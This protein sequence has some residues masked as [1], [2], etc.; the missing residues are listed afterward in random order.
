[1]DIHKF[2]GVI[3]LIEPEDADEEERWAVNKHKTAAEELED[4]CEAIFPRVRELLSRAAE[5]HAITLEAEIADDVGRELTQALSQTQTRKERRH[6]K[7]DGEHGTV[8]PRTTGRKRRKA[9]HS[10][11]GEGSVSIDEPFSGKRF[12]IIMVEEEERFGWVEGNRK[13]NKVYLGRQHEYWIAHARDR[14]LVKMGAMALLTGHAITTEDSNQPIMSAVIH[15][16]SADQKF[17]LTL[18]NMA[19]QVAATEEASV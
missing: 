3:T 19:R 15:C 13:S 14:H 6:R 1:M 10:D 8:L 9:R 12:S 11:A 16:D 18:G 17:Q 4:L 7:E 2:Y 5:E